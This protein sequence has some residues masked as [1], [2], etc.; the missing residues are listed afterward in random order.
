[1]EST[2][3]SSAPAYSSASDT[4]MDELDEEMVRELFSPAWTSSAE[5]LDR[6]WV[7]YADRVSQDSMTKEEYLASLKLV[8]R[9]RSMLEYQEKC[10]SHRV[11]GLLEDPDVCL[12][13]FQ[14]SV[15][16]IWEA[17][18][19]RAGGKFVLSLVGRDNPERVMQI[20][21]SLLAI[22]C[23]GRLGASSDEL[24]GAVFATKGW[25]VTLALWNRNAGD[26]KLVTKLKRR[27]RKLFDTTS[28]K[29][30]AHTE[31]PANASAG[32]AKTPRDKALKRSLV[33]QSPLTTTTI[34][35]P[36]AARQSLIEWRVV[37]AVAACFVAIAV[38]LVVKSV[39]S[40]E[41]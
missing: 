28:V 3:Y 6:E 12:R 21:S 38:A 15:A 19:N 31:R 39:S 34:Q 23:S 4:D 10:V 18:E 32:R 37:L 26:T 33:M 7:V 24:L 8:F 20:W 13:V 40:T 29:Y 25:G 5:A 41:L 27:L 30:L 35:P 9:F 11:R 16:P 2:D 17:P 22:M 36:P 14:S 1:M